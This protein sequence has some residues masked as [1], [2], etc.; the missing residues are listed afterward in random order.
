MSEA[1]VVPHK[2]QQANLVFSSEN[3]LPSLMTG[4]NIINTE[5]YFSDIALQSLSGTIF[6]QNLL[7]SPEVTDLLYEIYINDVLVTI[8]RVEN[9]NFAVM[10]PNLWVW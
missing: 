2:K 1:R 7:D 10:N 6:P 8:A 4:L 3:N 9:I 5:L